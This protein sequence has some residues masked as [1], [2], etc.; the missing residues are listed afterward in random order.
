MSRTENQEHILVGDIDLEA[1]MSFV[2]DTCQPEVMDSEDLMYILYTS[3][4][5]TYLSELD[6]T[7]ISET[8][9]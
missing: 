3:G 9:T 6:E 7:R 8:E 1:E 5:A 4:M 2:S